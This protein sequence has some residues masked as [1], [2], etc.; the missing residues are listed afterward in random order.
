MDFL[1]S[2]PHLILNEVTQF[3]ISK[4]EFLENAILQEFTVILRLAEVILR[5]MKGT[6]K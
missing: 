3:S 5:H 4:G 6:G 1:H 2:F